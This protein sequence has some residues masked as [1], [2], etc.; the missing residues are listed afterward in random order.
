MGELPLDPA[1]GLELLEKAR[2]GEKAALNALLDRLRPWMKK[3][4]SQLTPQHGK[5]DSSDVVQNAQLLIVRNIQK[6]QGN[7][8]G[9]FCTWVRTI[10]HN[11]AKTLA[12]KHRPQE[13]LPEGS[14]AEDR[15]AAQVDTPSDQV[16]QQE[17]RVV[18]QRA[19][20]QLSLEDQDVIL[21]R[22]FEDLEYDVIAGVLGITAEAARQ[23]HV[24]A[25]KRLQ[26]KLEQFEHESGGQPS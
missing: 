17:R 24:R 7:G 20:A 13:P 26:D 10:V 21:L 15:M 6:L 9:Q 25:L 19:I 3:L 16:V 18:V 1:S 2:R 23:R 4:A 12:A 8:V 14:S 22:D 11:E 5:L